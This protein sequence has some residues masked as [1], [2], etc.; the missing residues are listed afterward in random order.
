MA[1]AQSRLSPQGQISVPAEIRRKLGLA[2]G[3]VIERNEEAGKIVVRRAAT[4]ALED[5]H[6]ALFETGPLSPAA[7]VEEMDESIQDYMRKEHGQGR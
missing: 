3:S 1:I 5:I 6:K 4:V 7:T 2:P